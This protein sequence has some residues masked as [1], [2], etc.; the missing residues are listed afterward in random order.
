MLP[1]FLA[2]TLWGAD[3]NDRWGTR[4]QQADK[5]DLDHQFAEAAE[6]GKRAL[7]AAQ[8]LDRNDPRRAKIYLVL[9][10][11][12]RDWGYC[13]ESRANYAH[14]VAIWEKQTNPDAK[15]AFVARFRLISETIECDDPATAEKLFRA[16]YVDLRRFSSGPLD[17]ATVLVLQ[18]GISRGRRRYSEAEGLLRQ[19]AQIME[20][21]PHA[22]PIKI[23][24]LHNT[25][26]A[27]LKG[28]KRYDESLAEAQHAVALV[29]RID[30]RN[31]LLVDMLDSAACA[32]SAQGRWE[33]SA[34]VYRRALGLARELFGEDNR[35]TAVI[36]MNY[37]VVLRNLQRS[38]EA[39]VLHKKGQDAYRRASLS[40]GQTVDVRELATGRTDP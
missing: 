20:R 17:D 23:A 8:G 34:Q 12:Y 5:L 7:A 24:Q 4:L 29:E 27:V 16:E 6:S 33:E 19:A 28:L 39:D 30:A 11:I 1:C 10:N 32:L 18:A 37:A 25:L 26:A 40:N 2:F 31:P 38:P 15:F 21:S 36:M 35:F 22:N 3:A 14:S 9:G 13:A